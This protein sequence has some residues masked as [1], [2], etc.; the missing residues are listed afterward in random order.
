M[1]HVV[2]GGPVS[3]D[4]GGF[5]AVLIIF[6]VIVMPVW[7]FLHY[8]ARWRQAKMLTSDSERTLAEL[9]DLADQMQTRIDNLERLLDVAAPDWRKRS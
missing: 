1:M 6:M 7:L 3:M 2:P 8:G 4:L 9:S 5:W